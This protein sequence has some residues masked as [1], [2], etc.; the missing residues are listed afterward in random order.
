MNVLVVNDLH[1]L[2]P[3]AGVVHDVVTVSNSAKALTTDVSIDEGCRVVRLQVQGAALRARWDG[4]DP[5]AST[6]FLWSAN[7]TKDLPA[8][9]AKSIKW[10]RAT[11]SDATVVV[12]QLTV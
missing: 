1:M 5:D 12:A 10:I 8:S 3:V 6:G 7:E 2:V 9:L 4:T 11:G